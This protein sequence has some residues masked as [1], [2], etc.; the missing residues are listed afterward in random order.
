MEV[1]SLLKTQS[2]AVQENL[3]VLKQ[4]LSL[5]QSQ[6][7]FY[8]QQRQQQQQL[9]G[10]VKG[11]MDVDGLM[12]D[13]ESSSRSADSE[14]G[15]GAVTSAA[16]R[17]G[18]SS[19]LGVIAGLLSSHVDANKDYSWMHENIDVSAATQSD[20][21]DAKRAG[22]SDK[23]TSAGAGSVKDADDHDVEVSVLNDPAVQS[24][25]PDDISVTPT[26]TVVCFVASFSFVIR[27]V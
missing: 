27:T 20:G 18:S 23:G 8:S 16:H 9:R 11:G 15:G 13:R 26:V 6:M 2:D 24:M 1:V 19:N 7:N 14:H 10:S 5:L 17:G 25:L 12:H 3:H 21:G 22:S 4:S